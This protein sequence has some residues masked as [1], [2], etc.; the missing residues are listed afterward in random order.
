MTLV[1]M[2]AGMGSRYGGLKQIDP[3]GPCGEFIVD[4]SVYDAMK[5]GFDKV[6]FVIKEENRADFEQTIGKRIHGIKVEYAYQ[7]LNDIPSGY[8]VPQDRIKPWGTAHAVLSAK[9]HINEPFA[10]INSDD[11]YFSEA[12]EI[13]FKHLKSAKSGE[14]CMVNYMLKNTI[15][16]N[17]TV[18]RGICAG[19]GNGHLLNITE[20]SKIK[21]NGSVIQYY[22]EDGKWHDLEEDTPV[23]MNCWGFTPEFI[24]VLESEFK[25]FLDNLHDNPLKSEIYLPSVVKTAMD[26]GKCSVNMLNTTSKW[27][28]VTYREDRASVVS[29]LKRCAKSGIYPE[30]LWAG[31]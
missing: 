4:Y 17:G 15:T 20:M 9:D 3:V 7:S 30:N 8:T 13:I 25:C 19:D 29:F 12:F 10:V 24:G 27:Y 23:S 11:F 5:A 28:G 16:E 26:S 18:S 2:A 6:V 1:I 14:Y 21:R 31:V 22:T